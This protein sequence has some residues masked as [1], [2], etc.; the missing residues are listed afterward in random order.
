MPNDTQQIVNKA[1]NYAHV[2]R[3]AG[4]SYMAHIEQI[5]F[6]PSLKMADEHTRP[7]YGRKAIVP[8]E[9]GWPSRRIG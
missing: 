4:L 6:L 3:D 1:W 5:T 2:V 8:P 7:A 9:L